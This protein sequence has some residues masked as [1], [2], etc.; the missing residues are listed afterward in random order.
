MSTVR[1]ASDLLS[2]RPAVRRFA[3]RRRLSNVIPTVAP[4]PRRAKSREKTGRCRIR[5][6]SQP[7]RTTHVPSD[8]PAVHR[9]E[10]RA[11][12]LPLVRVQDKLPEW[13]RRQ[14]VPMSASPEALDG[15]RRSRSSISVRL[16]GC[17]PP[18]GGLRAIPFH[19]CRDGQQ[20]SLPLERSVHQVRPIRLLQRRNR[21]SPRHNGASR[22]SDVSADRRRFSGYL[23]FR[24]TAQ[25]VRICRTWNERQSGRFLL[26]CS[27]DLR[28]GRRRPPRCSPGSMQPRRRSQPAQKL[29]SR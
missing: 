11:S 4:L 2:I 13:P 9:G 7:Y 5:R 18:N 29:R 8:R 24:R 14:V 22:Q 25:P 3:K 19:T 21:S 15:P 12:S 16:Q 17:R 26:A 10:N 6:T 1:G 20:G 23:T 27:T 28:I